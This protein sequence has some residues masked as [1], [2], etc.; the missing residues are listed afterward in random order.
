MS[1]N[2][3]AP[4][5]TVLVT[6]P[7]QQ[8]LSTARRLHQAGY[9]VIIDPLL[10]VQPMPHILPPIE[11]VAA[12]VLTSANAV[13]SLDR[14]FT[15]LPVFAVGQATAAMARRKG[16]RE[17]LSAGGDGA[18]LVELVRRTLTPDAGAVL[19]PS[20]EDVRSGVGDGLQ[21]AGYDYRRVV[22]YRAV[23]ASALAGRTTRVL[24]EDRLDA[25]LF[26]S[27]RTGGVFKEL[28]TGAGLAPKLGTTAAICMSEDVATRVR[29]LPW[30]SV[31]VAERRSQEAVLAC[32]EGLFGTC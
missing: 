7:R 14:R 16:W 23:A 25:V 8:A 12:V 9:R 1:E 31:A 3:H 32:L 6:R 4:T 18:D 15:R 10:T 29:T 20:G 27:P 11:E 26:F 17:V 30:R 28:V 22:V 24:D 2:G 5:R 19:H 21:A 13:L